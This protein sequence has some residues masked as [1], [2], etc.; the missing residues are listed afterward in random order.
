[1]CADFRR[2]EEV[3]CVRYCCTE[4]RVVRCRCSEYRR[5]GYW[6]MY[7]MVRLTIWRTAV[8]IRH[9]QMSSSLCKNYSMCR[10]MCVALKWL[11]LTIVRGAEKCGGCETE[12]C[13]RKECGTLLVSRS[14]RFVRRRSC[15]YTRRWASFENE[16][17]ISWDE[18]NMIWTTSEFWF[19][20]CGVALVTGARLWF[21]VHTGDSN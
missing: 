21:T 14:R 15:R 6:N 4:R 3:W 20:T 18:M 5:T 16:C 10:K 8:K 12:E 11:F 9:G 13:T 7:S 19:Q 1:M 2:A 17:S